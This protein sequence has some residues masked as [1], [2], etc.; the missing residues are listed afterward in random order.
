[1]SIQPVGSGMGAVHELAAPPNQKGGN[2][3]AQMV[4][5]LVADANAQ[6]K[7]ADQAIQQMAMGQSDNI[8]QLM[9]AVAKADLSL[10]TV[11][12]IRNRLTEAYQDVMRM[13]V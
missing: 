7:N 5:D 4:H 11:L 12:E 10:R 3:F 1:M 9:I 6:Q 13:Q 8:H 2:A